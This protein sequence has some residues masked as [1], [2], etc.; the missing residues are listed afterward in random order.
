M[1]GDARY[2][3]PCK[4]LLATGAAINWVAAMLVVL[5]QEESVLVSQHAGIQGLVQWL[6]RV[7]G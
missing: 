1:D 2:E 7:V 6:A 5:T 3:R 4:W